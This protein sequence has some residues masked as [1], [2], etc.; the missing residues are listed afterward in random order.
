MTPC[1]LKLECPLIPCPNVEE[2]ERVTFSI[3]LDQLESLDTAE[4]AQEYHNPYSLDSD[5]N[6]CPPGTRFVNGELLII[7]EQ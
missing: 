5:A 7:R 4:S 1:P 6:W 3:T 2:C